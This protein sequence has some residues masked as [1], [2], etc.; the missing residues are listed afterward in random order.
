MV[1]II[2]FLVF[3]VFLVFFLAACAPSVPQPEYDKV[4]SDLNTARARLRTCRGNW[5]K[6]RHS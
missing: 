1:K 2:K 6:H 5:R 4:N 3:P